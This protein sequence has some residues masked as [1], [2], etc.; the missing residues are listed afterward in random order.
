MEIFSNYSVYMHSE[1]QLKVP[2]G[3]IGNSPA[4]QRW[5]HR[6]GIRVPEGRMVSFDIFVSFHSTRRFSKRFSSRPSGTYAICDRD[7]ALKRR[8]ISIYPSGI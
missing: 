7:P 1:G 5:E 3:T 4:F 2:S 8:A 6:I